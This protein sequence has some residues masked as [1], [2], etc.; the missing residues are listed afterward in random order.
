MRYDRRGKTLMK[1]HS[2]PPNSI[3]N[4]EYSSFKESQEETSYTALRTGSV[5]R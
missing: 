3:T 1:I 5:E 2:S 4:Y